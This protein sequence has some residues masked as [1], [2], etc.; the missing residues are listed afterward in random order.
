[1]KQKITIVYTDDRP[2][3]E[4]FEIRNYGSA[5]FEIYFNDNITDAFTAYESNETYSVSQGFAYHMASDRFDELY[6]QE[7]ELYEV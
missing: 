2:E 6:E 7:K 4:G 1:M 3:L 5:L